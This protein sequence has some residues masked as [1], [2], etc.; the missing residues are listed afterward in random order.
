MDFY[1]T[2]SASTLLRFQITWLLPPTKNSL[3][4]AGFELA[5]SVFKTAVLPIEL[6]SQRGLVAS[7][8]QFKWTKYFHHDLTLVLEIER[9]ETL[10]VLQDKR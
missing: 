6:S 4:R 1:L 7:L 8:I 5:P 2:T 10:R 3:A 9:I